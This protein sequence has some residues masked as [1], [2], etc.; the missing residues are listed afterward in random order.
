[1]K[2]FLKFSQF[3]VS[4]EMSPRDDYSV[5]V[6]EIGTVELYMKFLD[7]KWQMQVV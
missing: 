4:E 1:M 5:E 6:F 2:K 3:D 7:G